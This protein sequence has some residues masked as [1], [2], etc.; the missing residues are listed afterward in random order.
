MEAFV[1]Y[2]FIAIGEGNGALRFDLATFDGPAF[3]DQLCEAS[4]GTAEEIIR[5]ELAEAFGVYA[6]AEAECE[7]QTPETSSALR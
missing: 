1:L 3:N 5:N 7:P 2:V 6:T 4:K